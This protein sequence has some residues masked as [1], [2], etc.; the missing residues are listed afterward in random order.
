MDDEDYD[1]NEED[2]SADY[3]ITSLIE[4]TSSSTSYPSEVDNKTDLIISSTLC[5]ENNCSKKTASETKVTFKTLTSTSIAT[6]SIWTEGTDLYS[7]YD[8][9]TTLL[10]L[11]STTTLQPF[12]YTS[13]AQ[14]VTILPR[15][16]KPIR[17][18]GIPLMV[19]IPL[20]HKPVIEK[21]DSKSKPKLMEA[22]SVNKTAM[23][24]TLIAIILIAIVILAPLILFIRVKFK[25]ISHLEL[26]NSKHFNNF[27]SS[28]SIGNAHPAYMNGN[29]TRLDQAKQI[30]NTK[31]DVKEWYV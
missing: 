11:L 18:T 6:S 5:E 25:R 24:I 17:P 10:P 9:E 12:L 7:L 31:K 14:L 29:V 8:N 16:P 13:R 21:V 20:P 28:L 30:K 3:M 4:S 19:S 2:G 23:F 15:P 27:L 22:N 1:T 26:E